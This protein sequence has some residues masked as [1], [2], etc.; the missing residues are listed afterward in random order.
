M[1]A[2]KSKRPRNFQSLILNTILVAF[3]FLMTIL[4]KGKLLSLNSLSAIAFQIPLLGLLALAQM[5]PMLSGGIDLSIVSTANLSGIVMAMI[6][7]KMSF[8]GNVLIAIVAGLIISALVGILNGFLISV[9]SVPAIIATL[10]TM[11]F[12]RGIS[13][14]ITKG[15]VIAGFPKQFQF[16]GNGNILG[17]PVPFLIFVVSMILM[18]FLLNKTKYGLKLYM[19][20]SNPIATLFSAVNNKTVVFRTHLLSSFFAGVASI[21]M[22]SRFNAAQA[23]YGESYLLLTVLACILGGISPSGGFGKVSGLFISVIV[24]QIIATG[25]NLLGFSSYLASALWGGIL[26]FV[27]LANRMLLKSE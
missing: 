14:S 11:I 27:I 20:G 22:I 12:I 9:V 23:D 17:I 15:Y 21:V 6:M 3:I 24:L 4:T 16:I 26:I 25:F 18:I 13:L 5:A 7:T 8:S 1:L 19:L 2:E 10:G